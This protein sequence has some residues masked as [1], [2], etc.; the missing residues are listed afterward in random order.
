MPSSFTSSSR[1][2]LRKSCMSS[3]LLSTFAMKELIERWKR[4]CYCEL[5]MAFAILILFLPSAT[6]VYAVL[7]NSVLL[8]SIEALGLL[9]GSFVKH[10]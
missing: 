1:K 6:D 5:M 8:R 10:F 7:R 3:V 9:A 4:V 2:T